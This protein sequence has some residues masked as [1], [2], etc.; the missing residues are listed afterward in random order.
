MER[1][2]RIL[3]H[4]DFIRLQEELDRLELDRRFCR[5]G[6]QHLIDTARLAYLFALESSADLPKDVIY[7][8]AL[9]HDIGRAEQYRN[10]TPHDVAGCAAAEP[11]LAECGFA[12]EERDMILTAIGSHRKEKSRVSGGAENRA[13]KAEQ[14]AEGSGT[15]KKA[16][17]KEALAAILYHAD[18]KSRLCFLCNAEAEC[19]WA[20]EKKNMT[21]EY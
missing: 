5:H 3:R 14:I 12:E 6:M 20:K 10:G 17:A 11:I 1:V 9:L 13:G 21:L 7:A 19:N 15:Q 4:P 2:N 18:K 8:A 16:M